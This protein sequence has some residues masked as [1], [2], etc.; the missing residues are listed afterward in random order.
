M[1]SYDNKKI[2]NF[3]TKHKRKRRT[4]DAQ[5]WWKNGS[6]WYLKNKRQEY[7]CRCKEILRKKLQGQDIEFLLYR[8]TLWWDS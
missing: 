6:T 2:Y 8:K 7:R 5:I 1:K 3:K 4:R